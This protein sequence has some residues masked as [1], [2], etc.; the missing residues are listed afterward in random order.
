M[1]AQTEV[2]LRGADAALLVIDARAGLTPLDEEIARW[3]R[4][5]S[6][7]VVLVANKAEGNAATPASWKATRSAWA[8]PSRSAPSTARASPTST[9]R[10]FR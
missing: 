4:S 6:V 5:A 2:S 7:P 8:N 10:W 3:L 9:M 1:R